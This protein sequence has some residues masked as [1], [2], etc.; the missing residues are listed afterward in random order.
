MVAREARLRARWEL[1]WS[2]GGARPRRN[3]ARQTSGVSPPDVILGIRVNTCHT[4]AG[5][6]G[7]TPSQL[8]GDQVR[9]A[10]LRRRSC[11]SRLRWSGCCA[12]RLAGRLG[13]L[14]SRLSRN[15]QLVAALA[16]RVSVTGM[17]G[18]ERFD[19]SCSVAEQAVLSPIE[20]MWYA[21]RST[22]GSGLRWCDGR[23]SGSLRRL[24]YVGC[25]RRGWLRRRLRRRRCRLGTGGGNLVA[26]Q[27]HGIVVGGVAGRRWLNASLLVAHQTILP[28]FDAMRDVGLQRRRSGHLGWSQRQECHENK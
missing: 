11:R 8:M 7:R 28:P 5:R 26:A 12:R 21:R 24:N 1:R 9:R 22:C 19:A 3:M 2:A 23:L 14:D 25:R 6:T 13:G 16:D 20:T 18:R 27:A 4:V 15:G 17:I 10:G